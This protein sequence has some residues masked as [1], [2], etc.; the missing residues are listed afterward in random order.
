MIAPADAGD[1]R[2]EVGIEPDDEPARKGKRARVRVLESTAARR[3]D[4]RGAIEQAGDDPPLAVAEVGF[5]EA[6]EDLGDAHLRCSLDLGVAVDEREVERGSEPPADGGLARARHADQHD[7]A[8]DRAGR[9]RRCGSFRRHPGGYR[10]CVRAKANR[11]LLPAMAAALAAAATAQ[12]APTPPPAPPAP[13]EAPTSLLPDVLEEVPAREPVRP[14]PP[15]APPPGPAAL[16]GAAPAA[17]APAAGPAAA[18]VTPGPLPGAAPPELPGP[19][20]PAASAGLVT[21]ATVGLAPDLFAGSDGRFL[22]ALL[23]RLDGPLASR[24]GQIVVQRALL[25]EAAPPPGIHPGDWLAARVRALV[26]LGAAADAHRMLL[27]V[28]RADYTPRLIVAAAHAALAAGDPIGLCA[29]V[30]D[31]RAVSDDN[32]AF[33]LADGWCS[34]LAGDPFSANQLFDAARR[35]RLADPFDIQL[36]ERVASTAAATRSAGNPVWR[37]VDRLSAWRV[38]LA[39]A[40]GTAIPPELA[41]AAPPAMRAWMV[42]L[43]R[44]PVEQRAALVPEAAAMGALSAAEAGRILALDAGAAPAGEAAARPGGQLRAA[45]EAPARAQRLAALRALLAR[46]P[47]ESAARHGWRVVAAEAAARVAPDPGL[48]DEAPA[49]VEAMLA[50]G[51]VGNARAWWPVAA[52]AGGDVAARVAG[53]LAGV[54]ADVPA[55]PD[56][57]ARATTAHRGALLRAGLEGLGRQVEGDPVPRLANGWT[58]AIDAALAAGRRGEALVL[59]A[60][61]MQGLMAD[62]PPDH[63]RRIVAA[64]VAAGL[65]DEAGLMVAE[66]ATRG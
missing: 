22:A 24:W 62:L 21:E 50:A 26:A 15:A 10:A 14:P 16:P 1:K 44:V 39:G 47:E 64:L 45:L 4:A 42:R 38:G 13:S 48:A 51:F 56:R 61:G 55:E 41:A 34:A 5:A 63:F 40:T 28:R 8:P 58:A 36:A 46:V 49:L 11:L 43:P 2:V 6:G 19:S 20:R 23:N 30:A 65:R 18:P 52:E 3:D 17:S 7:G 37:E 53:L 25:T 12:E 27:R 31:G 32:P 9:A 66:A 29:F 33:V 35:R 59:A 57:F 60:T 54:D